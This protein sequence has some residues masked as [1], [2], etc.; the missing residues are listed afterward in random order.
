[1]SARALLA[2]AWFVVACAP[3]DERPIAARRGGSAAGGDTARAFADSVAASSSPPSLLSAA[4]LRGDPATAVAWTFDAVAVAPLP[5]ESID[6]LAT[7]D[8]AQFAARIAR[9]VDVL[10]SDTSVADFRG[11]PVVVRAA[12]RVVPALG[13]T[14]VVA[15]VARRVPIESAPLEEVYL[16]VA[17]PGA[18]A[19]VRD[20]LVERWSVR[21][22]GPEEALSVRELIAA[23]E[24]D[25]LLSLL[26]VHEMADGPH[27][28][29]VARR[30]G[31][32]S[33]AWEGRIATCPSP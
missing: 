30:D 29:V 5:I 16:V 7:R 32:W 15:L 3:S 8:S 25:G 33:A 21:D 27:V 18:R 14:V 31:G 23:H 24:Q 1:M 28:E 11:L 19:N 10:P 9:L 26:L 2:L 12:W 6:A 22:V 17:T 20:P 13:D 4:C